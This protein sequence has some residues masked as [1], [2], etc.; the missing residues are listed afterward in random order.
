MGIQMWTVLALTVSNPAF[1]KADHLAWNNPE[2]SLKV[3]VKKE[4]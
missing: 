1:N 3:G 2:T 4:L